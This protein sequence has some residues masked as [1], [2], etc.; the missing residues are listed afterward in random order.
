MQANGPARQFK[1]RGITYE[2][3]ARPKSDLYR[4]LLPAI[5]SRGIAL[6]DHP[7]LVQQIVGLERRTAWGGRDSIDHGDG[8]HDDIANACA[9]LTAM[10]RLSDGYNLD[11]LAS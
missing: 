3:A 5:N 6:L 4:D 8:Q 9:G 11:S 1:K 10:L 2:P 7:R